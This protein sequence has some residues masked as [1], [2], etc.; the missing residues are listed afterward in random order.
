MWNNIFNYP[1]V[2]SVVVGPQFETIVAAGR[3]Y[4]LPWLPNVRLF[5]ATPSA[6]LSASVSLPA[7]VWWNS[8]AWRGYEEII[9]NSENS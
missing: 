7:P 4:Q 2:S 1:G 8:Q 9:V 6:R 3:L 5:P